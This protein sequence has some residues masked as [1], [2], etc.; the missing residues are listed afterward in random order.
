MSTEAL[1]AELEALRAKR[2][3]APTEAELA[4]RVEEAEVRRAIAAELRAL[5][6]EENEAIKAKWAPTK[7]RQFFDFDPD[8]ERP[9]TIEHNEATC[10]LYTRFVVRGA[11][12]DQLERHGDAIT[13]RGVANDGTPDVSIDAAKMQAVSVEC[14]ETC[15]VFPTAE[16]Y[17]VSAEQHKA[18]IKASLWY[19]GAARAE[20]GQAAIKLGGVDAAAHRSKS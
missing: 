12:A 14:A 4:A 2:K 5:R 15:I 6:E 9:A 20:V 18:N 11:N 13:V 7:T 3:P 1:K 16:H 17:G 19:L 10:A 8:G